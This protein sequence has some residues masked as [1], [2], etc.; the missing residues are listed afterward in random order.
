MGSD[1]FKPIY[2]TVLSYVIRL[3]KRYCG[4]FVFEFCWIHTIDNIR[5]WSIY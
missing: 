2:A 1:Y 5:W 4:L 3:R